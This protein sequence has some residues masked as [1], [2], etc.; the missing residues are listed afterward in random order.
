MT[1]VKFYPGTGQVKRNRNELL[2]Y[3]DLWNDFLKEGVDA[4]S[5]STPKVNVIEQTDMF[6]LEIA[7]PG[8]KKT[9][10][11]INI[12]KNVLSIARESETNGAESDY[13][14]REFNFGSFE[15]SFHL[16]DTVN[17]EKIE[18]KMDNGILRIK[19]PKK[20]E[21]I[22]RGPRELKIS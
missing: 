6:E 15:R 21:A 4:V 12:D 3:S 5:Y 17:K 19:L 20:N 13:Q 9:D 22:D 16:P 11:N 10:I 18:A 2:S 14:S 7:L 8:V 1:L